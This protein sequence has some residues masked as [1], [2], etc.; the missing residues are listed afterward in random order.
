MSGL[1]TTVIVPS[2]ERH[3]VGPGDAAHAYLMDCCKKGATIFNKVL[4]IYESARTGNWTDE[5]RPYAA[6]FGGRRLVSWMRLDTFL[7]SQ[8]EE[9]LKLLP[10]SV[11]QYVERGLY[12]QYRRRLANGVDNEDVPLPVELKEGELCTLFYNRVVSSIDKATKKVWLQRRKGFELPFTTELSSFRYVR[13]VPRFGGFYTEIHYDRLVPVELGNL[14]YETALCV[15]FGKKHFVTA[16]CSDGSSFV[17]DAQ[18]LYDNIAFCGKRINELRAKGENTDYYERVGRDGVEDFIDRLVEEVSGKALAS[19]CGTVTLYLPKTL[20]TTYHKVFIYRLRRVV[21]SL[22]LTII[23]VSDESVEK[24]SAFD[25]EEVCAHDS[26]VGH[27]EDET[28]F[29]TA[30]GK[31]VHRGVNEAVNAL[32]VSGFEVSLTDETWTPVNVASVQPLCS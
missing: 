29:V 32:R 1:T 10:R 28:T 11:V 25:D 3:F 4:R 24:V 2:V 21:D 26:Y 16:V 9:V 19:R 15:R 30:A 17:G 27:V 23:E 18:P 12:E 13:I 31:R 5:T 6:V 8:G 7:S 22:G 20:P 14:D